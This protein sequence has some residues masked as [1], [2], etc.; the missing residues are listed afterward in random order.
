MPSL[1]LGIK[2]FHHL[3]VLVSTCKSFI[4]VRS[5]YVIIKNIF[6]KYIFTLDNSEAP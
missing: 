3:W 1:L 4:F 5:V 6:D 2:K